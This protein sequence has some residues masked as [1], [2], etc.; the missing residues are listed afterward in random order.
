MYFWEFSI[1][2]NFQ[3]SHFK[4]EFNFFYERKFFWVLSYNEQKTLVVI[5][6]SKTTTRT[7]KPFNLNTEDSPEKTGFYI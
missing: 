3:L 2:G 4:C 1:T 5:Q 6:M 7:R